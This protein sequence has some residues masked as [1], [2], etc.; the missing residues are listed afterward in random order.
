MLRFMNRTIASSGPGQKF[1]YASV[2]LSLVSD[3][4]GRS[5]TRTTRRTP[6]RAAR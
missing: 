3:S 1:R 2:D 6:W 4:G 5:S